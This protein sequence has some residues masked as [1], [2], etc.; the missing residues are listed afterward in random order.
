MVSNKSKTSG[1]KSG[2]L[3][4]TK[5]QEVMRKLQ[6]SDVTMVAKTTSF[7]SVKDKKPIKASIRYYSR[8]MD[9]CEWY[10]AEK[11]NYGLTYVHFNK[12]CYQEEP[13][14][15]A[16]QAHQCFYVKDP[17]FSQRY[18]MIKIVLRDLF[19]IGV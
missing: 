14:V 17:Y 15:L 11:D 6:N 3:F 4:H 16:S 2:T 5:W 10:M 18:Y 19:N 9:I 13:F 12:L 1:S 8:I 7:A